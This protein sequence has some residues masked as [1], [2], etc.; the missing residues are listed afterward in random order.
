MGELR[1]ALRE[2]HEDKGHVALTALT[3]N[4]TRRFQNSHPITE[5]RWSRMRVKRV[6]SPLSPTRLLCYLLRACSA[7]SLRAC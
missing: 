5:S 4:H 7:I 2:V 3:D 6:L 1:R